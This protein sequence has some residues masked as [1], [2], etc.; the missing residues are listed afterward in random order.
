[1]WYVYP[2]PTM[3]K[4]SPRAF[5]WGQYS[6]LCSRCESSVTAP[7]QCCAWLILLIMTN[8]FRNPAG[9]TSLNLPSFP[10][11]VVL[12]QHSRLYIMSQSHFFPVKGWDTTVWPNYTQH[13]EKRQ[14]YWKTDLI[15]SS[16]IYLIWELAKSKFKVC[17]T[18]FYIQPPLYSQNIG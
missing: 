4:S 7:A 13:G 15:F 9:L 12:S 18:P 5:Q 1:M 16:I 10:G 2:H 14:G 17:L 6:R 8:Q 3:E 11:L